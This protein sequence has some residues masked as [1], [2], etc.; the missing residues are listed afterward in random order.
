[1]RYV[2]RDRAANTAVHT[3]YL[4]LILFLLTAMKTPVQGAVLVDQKEYSVTHFFEFAP[5]QSVVPTVT[6][7]HFQ[8]GW[9]HDPGLRYQVNPAV[10]PSGFNNDGLNFQSATGNVV[11]VPR[12]G[13]AP[14]TVNQGSVSIG[15]DGINFPPGSIYSVYV[16]TPTNDAYAGSRF[17]LDDFSTGSPLRGT[18]QAEGWINAKQDTITGSPN[19]SEAYAFSSTKMDIAGGEELRSG[20]ILWAPQ[21][22]TPAVVGGIGGT[23]ENWRYGRDPINFSILDTVTGDLLEETLLDIAFDIRGDG[24]FDWESLSGLFSM[25]IEEG[26]FSIDI[27]SP[28]TTQQGSLYIGVDGGLV[29]T[30]TDSGM[31]DGLLPALGTPGNFGLLLPYFVLDYDFGNFNGHD[32]EIVASFSGSGAALA[33]V[34]EPG[35]ILVVSSGMLGMMLRRRRAQK[36]A[37]SQV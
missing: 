2:I 1:M 22:I 14:V 35:T 3:F 17:G 26:Y 13:G 37:A 16:P 8:H 20:Q 9:V 6:V 23:W 7:H 36:L 34:P 28:Y 31:F 18:M 29:T 15:S 4:V 19:P 21:I 12:G 10:Q 32:L 27:S 33:G 11:N 25:D 30:S 5:A 24:S